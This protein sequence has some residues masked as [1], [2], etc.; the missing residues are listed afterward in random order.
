MKVRTLEELPALLQGKKTV[1]AEGWF[2]IL[3]VEQVR[4]LENARQLGDTLVVAVRDDSTGPTG[5]TILNQHERATLVSGLRCV[6]HVVVIRGPGSDGMLDAIR[7][8]IYQKCSD[9]EIPSRDDVIR[10]I[11]ESYGRES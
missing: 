2:D 5:P 10:R 11:H 1:L 8:A 7:P 4:H 6:D 3:G 9:S